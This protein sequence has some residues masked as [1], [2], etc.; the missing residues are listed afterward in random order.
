MLA[1]LFT[2]ESNSGHY[3]ITTNYWEQ[4]NFLFF[5]PSIKITFN[6]DSLTGSEVQCKVGPWQY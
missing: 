6:R 4:K 1:K 5:S 2:M 3:I